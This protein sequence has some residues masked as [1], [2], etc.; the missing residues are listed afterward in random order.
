MVNI[1]GSHSDTLRDIISRHVYHALRRRNV[2][3]GKARGE[4][5]GLA[6]LIEKKV[7]AEIDHLTYVVAR[8]NGHL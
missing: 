5:R 4:S 3:D 8:T 2:P 6:E 7:E 1:R